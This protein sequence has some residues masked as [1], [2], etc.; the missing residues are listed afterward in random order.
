[1]RPLFSP[2]LE[3]MGLKLGAEIFGS[4]IAELLASRMKR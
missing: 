1:M 2:R 4:T 3:A